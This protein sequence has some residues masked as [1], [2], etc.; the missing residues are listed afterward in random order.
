MS[1]YTIINAAT[2]EVEE[3]EPT[4][5]EL[6]QRELDAIAHAEY[7]TSLAARE[8]ARE[9]AIDKLAALGLTV[10]EISAAFGLGG[11]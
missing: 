5:D 7:E 2:N 1:H 9:S 4:A 8:A 6:A 11:S 3:R 10:D